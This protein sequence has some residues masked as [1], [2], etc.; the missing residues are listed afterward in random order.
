MFWAGIKGP[1]KVNYHLAKYAKPKTAYT[2]SPQMRVNGNSVSMPDKRSNSSNQKIYRGR[3]EMTSKKS[4]VN[5]LKIK[6][7]FDY[8]T[9][10][11][12]RKNQNTKRIETFFPISNEE[13]TQKLTNHSK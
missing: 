10:E 5:D 2:L 4:K 1:C 9:K 12:K 7:N 3:K 13:D 8:R 11:V 6:T